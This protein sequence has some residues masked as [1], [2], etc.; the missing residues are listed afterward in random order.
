M[1]N[2]EQG[3]AQTAAAKKAGRTT[4]K[5]ARPREATNV[6]DMPPPPEFTSSPVP[7]DGVFQVDPQR[8]SAKL[9]NR[10]SD[11]EFQLA[12]H[13]AG[14]EQS[15]EENRRLKEEVAALQ[16]RVEELETTGED[17]EDDGESEA[18]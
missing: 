10:L 6:V 17:D 5:K 11:A 1:P 15:Q 7:Q 14:F 18:Q 16:R 12:L 3:R 8:I 4:A 9:R 2:R 13:E